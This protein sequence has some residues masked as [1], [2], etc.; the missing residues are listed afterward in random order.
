M[1]EPKKRKPKPPKPTLVEIRLREG[2]TVMKTV[3]SDADRGAIWTF[4]DTG[5]T[6]RSDICDRLVASG[7]LQPMN[8]GLFPGDSQT[9]GIA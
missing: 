8:D 9:W 4:T 6:A 3:R 7:V 2:A 5:R 1:S